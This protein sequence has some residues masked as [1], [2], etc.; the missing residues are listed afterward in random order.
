MVR[1]RQWLR[2]K[3]GIVISCCLAAGLIIGAHAYSRGKVESNVN[4][5]I[6]SE[7]D[8]PNALLAV[9]TF[10][11]DIPEPEPV[12][13]ALAAPP[14]ETGE[15][16][17]ADHPG[18][19]PSGEALDVARV[20]MDLGL[21][22][23]GT[24]TNNTGHRLEMLEVRNV[25]DDAR[26]RIILETDTLAAGASTELVCDLSGLEPGSYAWR[27]EVWGTWQDGRALAPFVV[28]FDVPEPE[29]I[30]VDEEAATE[31]AHVEPIDGEEA[32]DAGGQGEPV[33]GDPAPAAPDAEID[34]T[35]VGTES[36]ATEAAE[37]SQH[38]E[39][40]SE[41]PAG[42]ADG[43]DEGDETGRAGESDGDGS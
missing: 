6:V 40:A 5:L 21:L 29:W 3:P 24:V 11:P 32:D 9:A 14:S 26:G 13:M 1:S 41:Q 38:D 33:E 17:D 7:M 34:G 43:G 31:D 10:H 30:V 27:G 35:G 23:C 36:E 22:A 37:P 2:G 8:S 25:D 42:G 18:G 28:T 39:D 19:D 12:V 4:A 16:P 20:S 15:S